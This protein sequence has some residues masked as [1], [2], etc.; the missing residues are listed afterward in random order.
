M[1]VNKYSRLPESL[2]LSNRLTANQ[3]PKVYG[4]EIGHVVDQLAGEIPTINISR[5]LSKLYNTLNNPNRA[6]AEAATHGRPFV[7]ESLGY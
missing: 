3:R 5:Q 7:P 1:Y 4:H 2:S 6:G